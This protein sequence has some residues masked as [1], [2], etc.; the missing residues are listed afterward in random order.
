[1][2]VFRRTTNLRIGNV[3]ARR[4]LGELLVRPLWRLVS[5]DCGQTPAILE[6]Y[7]GEPT[8]K[9]TQSHLRCRLQSI[10]KGCL[11]YIPASHFVLR[12]HLSKTH[13]RINEFPPQRHT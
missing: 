4:I 11:P 7:R 2:A 13:A 3:S 5:R 12:T 10:P 9:T 8:Q 1:M 6:G